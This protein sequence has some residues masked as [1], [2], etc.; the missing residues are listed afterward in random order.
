MGLAGETG[1][2]VAH[3]RGCATQLLSEAALDAEF[4]ALGVGNDD[5]TTR[6]GLPS[7]V[8][9][10]RAKRQHPIEFFSL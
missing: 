5:P 4:V 7:V 9:D 1:L 6:D 8:D 3:P 10:A 2:E